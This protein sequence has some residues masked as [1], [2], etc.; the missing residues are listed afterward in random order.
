MTLSRVPMLLCN[1][2]FYG[3]LAAARALG[4]EGVPI[5]VADPSP[6]A[7][8]LWSR[9][10]TR[11]L[12][13][14]TF[15]DTERFSEWLLGVGE[16]EGRHVLY[17]TSDELS[18][19][20]ALHKDALSQRFALYT[21]DL[22]TTMRVLDKGKLN[23]H[24][25]AVGLEVPDTWLPEGDADLARIA[26]EATGPL[27][28]KP[29]T[30]VTFGVHSKGI[31]ASPGV[32]GLRAAYERFTR[33]EHEHGD[34]LAGLFPEAT[35]PMIQRYYTEAA[36][37]IYSLTGFRDQAGKAFVTLAAK[38]VL[39]RPRRLGIGLCFEAVPVDAGLAAGVARLCDRIG[40]YGV[41]EM[42]FIQVEGRSL[43]IDMNPRFY[44]QLAF[45]VARGLRLPQIAYAAALGDRAEVARLVAL[46]PPPDGASFA[47]CNR[48]EL[49]VQVRAQRL[50]NSM[51][52]GDA[53]RWRRWLVTHEGHLVDA[54][55][56]HTDRRPSALVVAM[57]LYKYFRHPRAFIRTIALDR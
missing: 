29:R 30:Q 5:T 24:A 51:T 28:I 21:P 32:D 12:R 41:F 35:Q 40:Y 19:T 55:A 42:E 4:S 53:A 2:T 33:G 23:E 7:P 52:A 3:T 50:A 13:C 31:L 22:E 25:R 14:P 15:E 46:P 38:K 56:D 43:L 26:R 49:G 37:G 54:V 57:Q 27:M 48:F 1:G 20:I 16:R 11:R 18:F 17:P 39:Q 36:A 10:V 44:S 9:H 8:A 34:A 6:M 45:E 47:Y